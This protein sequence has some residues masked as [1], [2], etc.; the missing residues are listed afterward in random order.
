MRE[1]EVVQREPTGADLTMLLEAR[2][3]LTPSQQQ[4]LLRDE[5]DG[6]VAERAHRRVQIGVRRLRAVDENEPLALL[7]L[8]EHER[9]PLFLE[10]PRHE[11]QVALRVLHAVLAWLERPGCGARRSYDRRLGDVDAGPPDHLE[12][13]LH[14]VQAGE[15]PRVHPLRQKPQLGHQVH[16]NDREAVVVVA[17]ILDAPDDPVHVTFELATR[18]RELRACAEELLRLCGAGRD[19]VEPMLVDGVERLA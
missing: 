15:D 4:L 5:R 10:Q 8:L 19:E 11:C 2:D 3:R 13:D 7:A 6:L 9:Q 17:A 1:I 16:A 14:G 12:N 18:D